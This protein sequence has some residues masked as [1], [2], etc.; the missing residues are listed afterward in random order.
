[1]VSERKS[2]ES[3]LST[4]E[5]DPELGLQEELS[6]VGMESVSAKKYEEVAGQT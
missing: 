3:V 6:V 5:V 1:M 2:S 4:S